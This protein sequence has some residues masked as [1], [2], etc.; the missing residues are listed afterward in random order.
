MSTVLGK[1]ARNYMVTDKAANNKV[2]VVKRTVL[3]IIRKT[4]QPSKP[5]YEIDDE[6]GARMLRNDLLAKAFLFKVV[7]RGE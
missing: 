3:D 4:V 1:Y 7:K 5:I 2:D 6:S